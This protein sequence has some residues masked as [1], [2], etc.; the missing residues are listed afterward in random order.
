MTADERSRDAGD[1]FTTNGPICIRCSE[2]YTPNGTYKG[3]Y[4][5][6]CREQ[7]LAAV[8]RPPRVRRP[9]R[10]GGGSTRRAAVGDGDDRHEAGGAR[11]DGAGTAVRARVAVPAVSYSQ[12]T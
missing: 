3:H 12:Y 10:S 11:A 6:A 5:P 9:G 8:S 1:R 2:F 7:P 4:C